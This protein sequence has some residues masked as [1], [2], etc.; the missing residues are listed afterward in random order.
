MRSEPTVQ[1]L[2]YRRGSLVRAGAGLS[3]WFRPLVSAIAEVPLDDRELDFHFLGRSADFQTVA[4]Q[5]VITFRVAEPETLARR[6]DFS[7]DLDAGAWLRSP[8]EKLHSTVTQLAQ[9]VV[10]DYLSKTDLRKLLSEGVEESRRR[11]DAALT[12]EQQLAEIGIVIVAVR[13]SA[14]RPSAETEKALE[15][16]T[17]ERIQEDADEA[18][19][20]R[21]AQAVE[22][23][24][25][26]QENELQ[27][28]I[29]LARR[30]EQLVVQ[31][32][33]NRRR[34]AEEDAAANLITAESTAAQTSIT[35]AADAK[36]IEFV[37]GA[38]AAI[39]RER[40]E[41]LTTLSPF[42]T[43]ALVLRDAADVLPQVGQLV[44]SPDLL[45]TLAGRLTL[46]TVTEPSTNAE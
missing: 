18:T 25:A 38:S 7:I 12:T 43:M 30:E 14:L 4:V 40:A 36:R 29:E 27:N 28:Q 32:G 10:W 41:L 31:Q 1:T 8:I 21:R 22:K 34:Q 9:Q 39:E 17:R 6:I 15:M 3:F 33:A 44:I 37:Q 5:G 35:A 16:P 23:E 24:R 45:A 46:G 13:V 2:H 19:F 26:I 42:T 11:I 20:Q